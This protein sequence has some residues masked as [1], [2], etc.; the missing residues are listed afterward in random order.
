V[1][2]VAAPGPSP[3]ALRELPYRK[4]RPGVRR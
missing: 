4:L 1:L 3:A 2:V